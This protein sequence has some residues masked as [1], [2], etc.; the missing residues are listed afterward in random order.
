MQHLAAL[1]E[2]EPLLHAVWDAALGEI[3]VHLMGEVQREVLQRQLFDRFGMEAS[4]T[5]AGVLYRETIKA[6]VEGVGHYEPL[7]HYAEVHLLLEPGEKGSGLRFFSVCPEDDLDRG[8]QR[9][10]LTH[11]R[12]KEHRGVLTGA[13]LTDMKITL[14]SGRAHVKH[15]E[16]GD[17][18]QATYR[19]VRQGLMSGECVLLEPWYD[20]AAEL[21]AECAGRAISDIQNAGGELF[22]TDTLGGTAMLEGR[23]PVSKLRSYPAV[24]AAYTHGRGRLSFT[25]SGYEPCPDQGAVIE[26]SGYDPERDL[27]NSADSV[28]CSHGA[29]SVVKWYD[30]PSF[31]HL[32]SIMEKT[33]EAEERPVSRAPAPAYTGTIEQD[34]EL[35]AIFERTY[36]SVKPRAF[37]SAPPKAE[38]SEPERREIAVRPAETEYLLVDGYNIIFAWDELKAA[39]RESLDAA[40]AQLSELLCNYQGFKKCEVILVFDAY[41]VPKNPGS[42]EKFHNITIVYTKEAETADSYIEKATY[43]L[44]RHSR[45]RVATSDGMEQL[46]ILGHGAMRVSATAFHAEVEGVLGRIAEFIQKSARRENPRE[47]EKAL[48]RAEEKRNGE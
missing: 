27:D 32:P 12:E 19:A 25:F 35:M 42:V 5:E 16:G 47:I 10:I 20:I 46:I 3:R 40:R 39:A 14:V 1:E 17:F 29:G 34:K 37:I 7:R 23:G 9:L 30:V 24:V 6:P 13:P 28:F 36:G 21:P 26:A 41:R 45:V 43:E 11:L 18:R 31:M 8:W 33:R 38:V 44:G 48:K 2:E 15:T 4:F 22:H